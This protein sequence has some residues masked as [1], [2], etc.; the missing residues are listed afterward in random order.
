MSRTQLLEKG[1]SKACIRDRVTAQRYRRVFAGVYA[2]GHRMLGHRGWWWASVLAGGEGSWLSHEAAAMGLGMVELPFGAATDNDGDPRILLHVTTP[3]ALRPQPRLTVHRSRHPLPRVDR[4]SLDGIPA[5]TV[6]RTIIDLA[7]VLDPKAFREMT[8][9][10]KRFDAAWLAR[11]HAV[12]PGR[13]GARS[14]DR[15]LRSIEGGV[16]KSALERRLDPFLDRFGLP[17]PDERNAWVCRLKVDA[18]YRDLGLVIELDSRAW[19]A[20]QAAMR[21]DRRRDRRLA[22][23]DVERVRLTSEDL[24]DPW[25]QNAASDLAAIIARRQG[26]SSKGGTWPTDDNHP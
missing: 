21:E 14:V 10:L 12:L 17:R 8:D 19:H 22:A 26:W 1:L 25:A 6:E 18:V 4:I 23:H 3:R 13:C 15:L 2:V 24:E 20:Q 7:D 16:T 9:G 5:T 11:R